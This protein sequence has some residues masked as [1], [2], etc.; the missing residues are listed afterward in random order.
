[1]EVQNQS[2]TVLG[3]ETNFLVNVITVIISLR[4]KI[5][6]TGDYRAERQRFNSVRWHHNFSV[7]GGYALNCTQVDYMCT[8][9]RAHLTISRYLGEVCIRVPQKVSSWWLLPVS[10]FI[11]EYL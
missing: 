11:K 4:K 5:Q 9:R 2:L 7:R 10:E 3:G 1:M 8:H 6:I